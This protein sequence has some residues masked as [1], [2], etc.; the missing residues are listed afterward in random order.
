LV[1][2]IVVAGAALVAIQ[3]RRPK[4]PNP[5]VGL[6]L[7]PLEAG[8]WLNVDT[9]LSADA[10]RGNIVLVDFWA[11]DCP[12]CVSDMPELVEFHKQFA[13]RG[14]KVVGLT[15]EPTTERERVR[16]YVEQAGIDWPIGYGAG[17][18]FELAGVHA[19]PTYMLFDRTGRSVWGGHSLDGLE[20]ATLAALAREE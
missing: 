3:L 16:Q 10:L 5:L 4:P 9:P 18:T 7:P 1:L 20:D 17:F 6:G 15:H 8:G 12:S 19:T 11:T 14:V 2:L 13:E